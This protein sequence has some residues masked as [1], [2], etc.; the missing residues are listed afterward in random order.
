MIRDMQQQD[1]SQAIAIRFEDT[2]MKQSGSESAAASAASEASSEEMLTPREKVDVTAVSSIQPAAAMPTPSRSITMTSPTPEVM[3]PATKA[4]SQKADR[5]FEQPLEVTEQYEVDR[6]EAFK[7]KPNPSLQQNVTWHVADAESSNEGAP[8]SFDFGNGQGS[9]N[10]KGTAKSGSGNAPDGKAEEGDGYDPFGDGSFPGGTGTGKGNAGSN[11]G[12]G[13]DGKG[14]QWGDFAGDG[15]FNRKV[16]KRA[17][18]A[19]IADLPGKI[20]INLCVDQLGKVVF[21]QFD[22]PNSTI[23]SK[24][25][26]AKA[27]A[28]AKMYVFDED[29]SAPREQCGRLTFIFEIK[30]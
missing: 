14:M 6:V 23:R 13:Q 21:A 11:T 16:I 15:L 17:P 22:S 30:K 27:E 1:F 2:G 12:V 4:N 28:Y 18:I 20:V 7:A 3:L 10:N 29:P 8:T 19:Q 25:I 24:T 9:G 5:F 26:T